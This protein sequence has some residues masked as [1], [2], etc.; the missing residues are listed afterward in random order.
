MSKAKQPNNANSYVIEANGAEDVKFSLRAMS[1]GNR[2][3]VVDY[4]DPILAEKLQAR[5][6]GNSVRVELA[7]VDEA[8]NR[9]AVTR[10]LPGAS[11]RIGLGR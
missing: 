1:S 5:E 6:P 3:D 9:W 8:A 10:H 4:A 2:Y 11:P 7:P